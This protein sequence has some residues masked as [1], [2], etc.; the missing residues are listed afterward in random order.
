MRFF[1]SNFR[2]IMLISGLLTCTMFLGL[3]SPQSSLQ[4]NFGVG[5]DLNGPVAEIVVRNWGALIGLVGAMLVYG[6]VVE[7]VRAF[8]LVIAIISK[9]IFIALVMIYGRQFLGFGAGIDVAADSVMIVLFVAY[10]GL[11]R[12]DT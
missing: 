11:R 6:A 2:W 1:L 10:L 12:D 9:V 7:K 8:A 3:I 4:S 5:Q